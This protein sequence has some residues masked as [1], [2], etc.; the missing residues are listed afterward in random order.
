MIAAEYM[1]KLQNILDS[2]SNKSNFGDLFNSQLK[3]LY[4]DD[5]LFNKSQISFSEPHILL[6]KR[7]ITTPPPEGTY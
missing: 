2:Q 4:Y 7:K 5:E 3:L 1:S 6:F